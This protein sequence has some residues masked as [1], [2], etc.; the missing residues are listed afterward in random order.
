MLMQKD[1]AHQNADI[2]FETYTLRRN[3]AESLALERVRLMVLCRAADAGQ[4]ANAICLY[5]LFVDDRLQRRSFRGGA[6]AGTLQV[7]CEPD[8]ATF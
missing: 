7:E 1:A 8:S 6:L 2:F 3:H 4:A 5:G